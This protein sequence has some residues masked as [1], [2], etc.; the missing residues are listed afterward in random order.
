[1]ASQTPK[2]PVKP[3]AREVKR[4]VKNPFIYAGTI[5]VL[6][7]VVIAFVFVP[8]GTGSSS[9]T[10]NGRTID[11]GSYAGYPIDYSQGSYMALQVRDLNDRLTQSGYTQENY[12]LFNYQVWR[13]AFERT[14]IRLGAIDAVK[15]AGCAVTEGW[16]DVKVAQDASFQENGKFSAQKYH[17]ATLAAKLSV[18]TDLRDGALYQRYVDDVSSM[19]PSSKEI[20]FVKE[21]A[22]ETRSVQYAA[23]PLSS[24]PDSEVAAWGKAHADLF[25]S[26]YLSRVTIASSEADAKKLLANIAGKKTTFE[27]AAKASSK[28]AYAQKGG[29]EGAKYYFELSKELP[30]KDDPAKLAALKAGE[31]SPVL[32]TSAGAWVFFRA[33]AEPSAADFAQTA[34]L[35]SVRDYISKYERGTME[36]WT[37]AKAKELAASGGAGFEAAAKKAGLAVKAAGPFPINY[38]DLV[39]SIYGQ[40]APL[41]KAVEPTGSTELSGAANSEKFLTAA[42]STSPGAVADPFIL[43]ENVIVLKVKEAGS[44]K[45]DETGAISFYYPYFFQT[46]ASSEVRD[47]F[48]NSPALK[49]DFSNVYFKYFKPTSATGTQN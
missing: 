36:D 30:G 44:A 34:V 25:R 7:I 15:K 24:Y 10:G 41:F 3:E 9:I 21:M 4:G 39:V 28:D 43:G 23:Y 16:L 17:D 2:A 29:A 8:M 32:K 26:L 22:K 11:F 40:S 37:I 47:L 18:R 45:D 20:D 35:S 1:M 12:P 42:F 19:G 27:E 38:G 6:I 13:G 48:M 31:L 46:K 5:I 14:V 49:D 33:D